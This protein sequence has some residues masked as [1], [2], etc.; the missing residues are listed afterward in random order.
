MI[1]YRSRLLVNTQPRKMTCPPA[2][3]RTV[4]PS[5]KEMPDALTVNFSVPGEPVRLVVYV[6]CWTWG[7]TSQLRPE[8]LF[9]IS[10]S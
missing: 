7:A 5:R 10:S 3:N 4:S 2:E 6:T 8:L 1:P 9:K